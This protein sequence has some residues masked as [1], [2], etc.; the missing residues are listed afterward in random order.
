MR[1]ALLGMSADAKENAAK[2]G[3]RPFKNPARRRCAEPT[4]LTTPGAV[5]HHLSMDIARAIEAVKFVRQMVYI[6]RYR[7]AGEVVLEALRLLEKRERL[8]SAR[9]QEKRRRGRELN[10]QRFG[11][12]EPA[13]S[14]VP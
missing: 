4:T 1:K 7:S 12:P 10:K 5:R 6:G 2:Q 11:P 3:V 13:Q 14:V 9:L 8:R